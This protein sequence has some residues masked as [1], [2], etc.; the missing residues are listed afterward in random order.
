MQSGSKKQVDVVRLKNDFRSATIELLSAQC[1]TDR[2]R[3]R[4]SVEEVVACAERGDLKKAIASAGFL[5]RFFVHL[6]ACIK[7]SEESRA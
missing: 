4:Y 2:V 5:H 6:E 3:L 7:H 1:A